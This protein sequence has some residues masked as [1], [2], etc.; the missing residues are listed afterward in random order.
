MQNPAKRLESA[1]QRQHAEVP[2]TPQPI[3]DLQRLFMLIASEAYLKPPFDGSGMRREQHGQRFHRIARPVG[4]LRVAQHVRIQ[5]HGHAGRGHVAGKQRVGQR[6][7]QQPPR[8]GSHV[9]HD[10]GQ[11]GIALRNASLLERHQRTQVLE[12]GPDSAAAHRTIANGGPSLVEQRARL[13]SLSH[14]GLALGGIEQQVGLKLPISLDFCPVDR[15]GQRRIHPLAPGQNVRK[16]R[17]AKR[18]VEH[19]QVEVVDGRIR[20]FEKELAG[21]VEVALP[22]S[23]PAQFN[24]RDGCVRMVELA[25]GYQASLQVLRGLHVLAGRRIGQAKLHVD[26]RLRPVIRQAGP[27]HQGRQNLLGKRIVLRYRAEQFGPSP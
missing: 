16:R 24:K 4:R 1:T 18:F 6:N 10:G 15:G 19:A 25:G 21:R 27:A 3:A 22:Q 17:H 23:E 13:A 14:R 26:P 12:P 2:M 5:V 11:R 8:S 7:V 9:L 20:G